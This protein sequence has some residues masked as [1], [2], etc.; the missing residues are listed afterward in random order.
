[1]VWK[2]AIMMDRRMFVCTRMMTG[3]GI[4]ARNG[5][6]MNSDMKRD[7]RLVSMMGSPTVTLI[8]KMKNSIGDI[9]WLYR[10]IE[11]R[12]TSVCCKT[13]KMD[14]VKTSFVCRQDTNDLVIF[15]YL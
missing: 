1:M 12:K 6:N 5:K 2:T 8:R 10:Y 3:A 11:N 13:V 15:A 14:T 7:M 9:Y 4:R